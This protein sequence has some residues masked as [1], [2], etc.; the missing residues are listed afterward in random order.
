MEVKIYECFE[1]CGLCE[2]LYNVRSRKNH[3]KSA[4]HKKLLFQ[5]NLTN[6]D[7]EVSR[8]NLIEKPE[9]DNE[10]EDIMYLPVD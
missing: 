6:L 5:N 4:K 9:E 7:I 10:P 8:Y 1:Y 2:K 3:L